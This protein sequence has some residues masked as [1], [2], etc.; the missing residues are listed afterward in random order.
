MCMGTTPRAPPL[1]RHLG[2][3]FA[4][5]PSQAT[6]TLRDTALLLY[7]RPAIHSFIHPSN[8]PCRNLSSSNKDSALPR[9]KLVSRVASDGGY[10]VNGHILSLARLFLARLRRPSRCMLLLR[11]CKCGRYRAMS[12]GWHRVEPRIQVVV[13]LSL[14]TTSARKVSVP[15]QTAMEHCMRRSVVIVRCGAVP[16]QVL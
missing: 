3:V 9:V 14:C 7:R 10:R 1:L 4:D 6:A 12:I 15:R 13:D 8:H 11:D 2:P 16:F 5:V